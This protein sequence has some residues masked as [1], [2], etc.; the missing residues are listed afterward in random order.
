MVRLRALY[1]F[2]LLLLL[3]AL[4]GLAAERAPQLF[5]EIDMA[6][7]RGANVGVLFDFGDGIWGEN[8]STAD[9]PAGSTP[10]TVRL[11]L[12]DRP[13]RGLR[14][15]PTSDDQPVLITGMR[16]A[17]AQGRVLVPLDVQRLRPM[18]QIESIMPEA[19]GMRVRPTPRADDPMLRIDLGPLQ[20]KLHELSGRATVTPGAVVLLALAIGTLLVI[21]VT[22]AARSARGA[23]PWVGGAGI[24]CAV[25]GARLLWLNLFSRAV[26][27]WDEWEGDALYVLIPFAG[28]FLDWGA[29]VMPQWEHR[30]L[31]TRTITLFG[32]LL[33]GE[34]DPR[35]AMTVSAA[36][37][38][39]ATALLGQALLAARTGAGLIAAALLA[40]TAALPYDFNN[41]LWGGQTQMYGLVLL[42]VCALT[43]ASTPRV[44]TG[45]CVGAGAAGL[46]ALF[47]MG[48]GLVGSGCAVGICLVRSW[49]EPAQRRRLLALGAVFFAAA[50]LGLVLHV[51]SRAHVGFY[52]TSF[53]QFQRAFIGVLSW[54]LPPWIGCAAIVWLPWLINGVAILRRREATAL[55]WL[56]VGL[57]AWAAVDAVAL[58][59]ARQYEGPPFDSRFFTPISVGAWASVLST[60]SLLGRARTRRVALWPALALA[61][62]GLGWIGYG[63]AGVREAAASR[64]DRQDREQR[65]RGFLA[66]GNRTLVME[67]PTHA[68]GEMVLDR[69]ESPLL[70]GLLPAPFR[71]ELAARPGHAAMADAGPGPVTTVARTLMKL[72]A[73]IALLGLAALGWHA[74]RTPPLPRE[75]GHTSARPRAPL[76]RAERFDRAAYVLA[77]ALTIGWFV[78]YNA[79]RP[80]GLVDEPGHF[81]A[82]YHF[83]TQQA[84]WPQQ[85]PMLPGYHYIVVSLM[86][87]S[88][89]IRIDT[90]TRLVTTVITLLGLACFALAWMRLHGARAGR[91]TLLL[92]LMPLAQPFT[93]MA[94]TDWPAL[95]FVFVAAWAQLSGRRAL[96]AVV[97]A[98]AAAIRQTN[99]VWVLFF[100]AWELLCS[101]E[102]PRTWFRRA[103]WL[104]LLGIG[105]AVLIVMAGRLTLGAQ[106]GNEFR[107]NPAT[108]HFT[109]VI[110]GVLG[111]PIWLAHAPAVLARWREAM[112]V[113]PGKAAAWA[114]GGIV[115]AAIL[116]ATF[117]NPH[118]WNRE[119]FW[120]GCTF[121]L[122][123]NWPLV[124]IDTHPWLRVASG[125]NIVLM[126]AA[127]AIV[128]R[129]QRHRRALWLVLACGAVPVFT[130]SLIEPRYFIPLGGMLLLFLEIDAA[131]W[132]RLALW[133]ALL[134]AVHAP[135]VARALSL[136]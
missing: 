48:A 121:T 133:W 99:L 28:G 82:V 34:W 7:E 50:S 24:F 33:N 63:V 44:T 124:W 27:F 81:A 80:F 37:F 49:L 1:L 86:Q 126:A 87:L 54:P 93:G 76:T 132:R 102:P 4:R 14:F 6:A 103:R 3:T 62:V 135:F 57:G 51:S 90:A 123:R 72:G 22:T 15:D 92:V 107:F 73:L 13:I 59:Y 74:R 64:A 119:L 56:A 5:L 9:L 109:G 38:A 77:A 12:P 110:A 39:A 65:V 23:S 129:A 60:V 35:V 20:R 45:A 84:G 136:W 89:G 125:I 75:P 55:E 10:Q 71:R 122:L 18:N 36:M 17:D 16:L 43:I 111:L 46:L 32:T 96:A 31:L 128:L 29:L 131:N 47:T 95:A 66:T 40:I 108:L 26:P 85:M 104:L 112:R 127:V 78:L 88:P 68:N 19:G 94:Y 117:A 67:R 106:H 97:L 42:A 58:G 105:A 113:A 70:Q 115:A 91:I 2:P 52:A 83:F 101:E 30:I 134:S 100:A 130:N 8:S 25:F 69:L 118:V 41:L 21:G 114:A 11:A 61:A 116:T 98:A 79:V 53:A 120:E